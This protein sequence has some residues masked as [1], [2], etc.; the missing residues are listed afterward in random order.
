MSKIS[1]KHIIVMPSVGGN[2]KYV[3]EH[4]PR[5]NTTYRVA[6]FVHAAVSETWF[7]GL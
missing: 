5:S 3:S 2:A 4:V 1:S 7:L 6:R